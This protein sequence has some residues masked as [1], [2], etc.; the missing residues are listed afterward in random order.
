MLLYQARTNPYRRHYMYPPYTIF[1][2]MWSVI[3]SSAITNISC[4]LLL[5]KYLQNITKNTIARSEV[6][7]KKDRKR[8]FV[9]AYIGMIIITW[10]VSYFF[11]VMV[12][13]RIIYLDCGTRAFIN[14]V[15]GDFSHCI[16]APLIMIKGSNEI[17]RKVSK[18]AH[19][20][21]GSIKVKLT[22]ETC[23][24]RQPSQPSASNIATRSTHLPMS[25]NRRELS[26]HRRIAPIE[27]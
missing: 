25:S 15:Y 5:F 9:P 3:I 18:L 13:Y 14:A 1:P 23:K 6:D 4:N 26:R 16:I 10:S 8:N 17:S 12:N 7:K 22:F 21:L 20:L 2:L 24:R 27:I 11:L 19:Y